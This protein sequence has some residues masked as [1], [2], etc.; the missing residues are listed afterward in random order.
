MEI[1]VIQAIIQD[2]AGIINELALLDSYGTLVRWIG[3]N[4]YECTGA[5]Y[6]IYVKTGSD[7]LPVEGRETEVYFPVR[8]TGLCQDSEECCTDKKQSC[9]ACC[10]L[11]RTYSSFFITFSWSALFSML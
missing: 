10:H 5:P 9:G 7:S 4:G 3:K 2:M 11:S 8:K 6:E 1:L